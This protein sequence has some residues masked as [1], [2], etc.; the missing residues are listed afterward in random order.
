[1]TLAQAIA[2]AERLAA[3]LEEKMYVMCEYGEYYVSDENALGTFWD[4]QEPLAC[5]GKDGETTIY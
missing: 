3:K 1:M 4:E 5:V 2:K